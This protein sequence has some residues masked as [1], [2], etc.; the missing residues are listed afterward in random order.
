VG[1]PVFDLTPISAFT[2]IFTENG[3]LTTEMLAEIR[4]KLSEVE[5][6]PVD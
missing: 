1:V 6:T 4:N 5:L 3:P 2:A